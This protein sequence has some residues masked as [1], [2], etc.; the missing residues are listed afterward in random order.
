MKLHAKSLFSSLSGVVST[1]N[2][3]SGGRNARFGSSGG[4]ATGNLQALAAELHSSSTQGLFEYPRNWV[5]IAKVCGVVLIAGT[6]LRLLLLVKATLEAAGRHVPVE[7][8]GVT[9]WQLAAAVVCMFLAI[10]VAALLVSLFP[11][12]RISPQGLG[13]SQLLGWR[14]VAWSQVGM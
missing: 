6:I 4:I 7:Y 8:V 2:R 3:A 14:R 9:P 5:L 1:C 12:I 11:S 10:A 13:I